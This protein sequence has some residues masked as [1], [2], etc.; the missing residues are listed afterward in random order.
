MHT[1]AAESQ[2]LPSEPIAPLTQT[3]LLLAEFHRLAVQMD[4]VITR[5][6]SMG[7]PHTYLFH[8]GNLCGDPVKWGFIGPHSKA[9]RSALML[10]AGLDLFAAAGRDARS[11]VGPYQR[12]ALLHG[13]RGFDQLGKQRTITLDSFNKTVP[14]LA[15]AVSYLDSM[16]Y[17]V[18]DTLGPDAPATYALKPV[19]ASLQYLVEALA[20]YAA[21]QAI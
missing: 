9:D 21:K 18:R 16:L 4:Q 12:Q 20:A 8:G 19:N 5:L 1:E 2:V 7:N 3:D 14:G 15:D 17:V 11:I 6:N 13:V 10:L